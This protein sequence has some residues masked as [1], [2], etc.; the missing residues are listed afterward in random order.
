M[1]LDVNYRLID[2]VA[3][4]ALRNHVDR[5]LQRHFE[6]T[7]SELWQRVRQR[8]QYIGMSD[9]PKDIGFR[10]MRP[11]GYMQLCVLNDEEPF[12]P[13]ALP[14]P[15]TP[16]A[17]DESEQLLK[18]I[19]DVCLRH[20]GEGILYFCVFAVLAPNGA[21]P[22]H[23]DMPHDINKKLHSHHLHVPL[24]NADDTE[25]TV[26]GETFRM[27]EGGVYE[28]NNMAFHSVVNR[29]TDYRVNLLLDYCPVKSLDLRNA[30]SR[31]API[32]HSGGNGATVA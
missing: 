24:T 17:K 30:P 19:T 4:S 25:F 32:G 13:W 18:P 27:E 8:S 7:D 21:I 29:G 1:E 26:G 31:H 20:Y 28:I 2:R 6:A 23:R 22:S 14:F 10:K 3:V 11:Q 16:G 9:R 12:S 15:G 5:H